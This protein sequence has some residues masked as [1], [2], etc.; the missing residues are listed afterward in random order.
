MAVKPEVQ[1]LL[2]TLAATETPP[3][4]Q[5]D[6]ADVRALYRAL[7]TMAT[8][9][10]VASVED[11]TFP[12]P[13]GPVPV[14]IYRPATADTATAPPA[15]VWFHG[16]GFVIGDIETADANARD[17]AAGAGAVVVSVGYRLAPEDPFPAGVDDAIAAVR[18]VADDHDELGVDPGRLAVGGDSAGGNLATVVAQQLAADGGPALRFQLLV[19]PVTDLG[20]QHPSIDENAD[21]YLLT[22][23]EMIWFSH[24]YLGDRIDDLATDPRVSPLQAPEEALADLPP[25]LVITAE[26]DPLR[27]E[28][29]AYGERLRQ[30]GVDVTLTRYDGVIHG[31]YGMGDFVPDGKAAVQQSVEA[32]RGAFA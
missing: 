17:L 12:G 5:Q 29:E 8:R 1:V 9:T 11:R 6:P 28:G 3:V 30:A 22:K 19:Y 21:G 10:E 16:G 25:A 14:R 13:A 4:S 20:L 2:D 23:D 7:A 24:H 18:W 32:L 15:L 26:Y 31:F 27:D